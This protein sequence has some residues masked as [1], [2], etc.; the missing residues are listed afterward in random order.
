[1]YWDTLFNLVYVIASQMIASV[2]LKL[3]GVWT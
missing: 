2:T 3:G 1:M